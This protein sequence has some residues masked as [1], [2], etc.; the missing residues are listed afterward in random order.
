LYKIGFLICTVPA[1]LAA[2]GSGPMRITGAALSGEKIY[3][4][5]RALV[6]WD[7][8]SG[9]QR[10][11]LAARSE[12]GEGGCVDGDG[13]ILQ[14]G[15]PLGELVRIRISD[16][17]RAVLDHGVEMHD[18]AAADL[19]GRHGVLV[20]HR[21]AQVRFYYEGG[22]QEV[23]SFYTASKQGG[24]LIADVN[25]D[26][27]PD[28]LCGNYWI[29]SPEAFELPWR[30]FAINTRHENPES[31][32]FRLAWLG[33][34]LIAAQGHVAQGALYRY[35]PAPDRTQQWTETHL[36][37]LRYPHAVVSADAGVVIGENAGPGSRV[38]LLPPDGDLRQIGTTAGA[39]TAIQV[40][41]RI[42]LVGA[43]GFTWIT[44]RRNAR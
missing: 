12:F 37:D 6:E 10:Q 26:K 15:T 19:F 14:D 44:P 29:R 25:G 43:E 11:I 31:A 2:A 22:V 33:G 27:R 28:I 38:F 24:L 8:A 13:V 40:G 36:A 18:C 34:A 1:W 32:N 20:V 16:G 35:S 7:I 4:W 41:N 23:Y 3:T 5:G 42:A 39:H 17:A 21:Y 30:L 9:S